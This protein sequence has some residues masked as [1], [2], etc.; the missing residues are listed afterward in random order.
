VDSNFGGIK[1]R[2]EKLVAE[3]D[4]TNKKPLANKKRILYLNRIYDAAV[5]YMLQCV[6]AGTVKGTMALCSILER[7]RL[8]MADLER[9]A[10]LHGENEER[11]IR[12]V[13]KIEE[14]EEEKK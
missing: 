13:I 1:Q 14:S 2:I 5:I 6:T 8:E 9:T 10:S 11:V 12:H 7:T 4:R 3:R